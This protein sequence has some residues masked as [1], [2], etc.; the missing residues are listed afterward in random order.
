MFCEWS[1]NTTKLYHDNRQ[2]HRVFHS[3][4]PVQCAQVSG[5]GNSARIAITMS[6]GRTELYEGT[7][8]LI[9]R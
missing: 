7:G 9:R 2:L 5:D 1:G 6:N 3:R 4:L 8:R